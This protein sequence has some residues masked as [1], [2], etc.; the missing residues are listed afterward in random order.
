MAYVSRGFIPVNDLV[1]NT[2]MMK[3]FPH[4]C[5]RWHE[6]RHFDIGKAGSSGD[7]NGI[8][9]CA[10]ITGINDVPVGV[11]VGFVADRRTLA[12]HPHRPL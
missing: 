6:H 3:L 8:P 7:A 4:P 5:V 2:G 9:D 11:V 12:D 10:R 1:Y